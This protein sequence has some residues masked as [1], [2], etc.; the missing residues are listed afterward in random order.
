[1]LYLGTYIPYAIPTDLSEQ[2]DTGQ[3]YDRRS[4]KITLISVWLFY[5]KLR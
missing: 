4:C 1:M 2:I 5:V 3:L